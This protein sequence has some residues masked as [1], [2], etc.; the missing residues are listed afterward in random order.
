MHSMGFE[1]DC[2]SPVVRDEVACHT[3][4]VITQYSLAD[5]LINDKSHNMDPA[6]LYISLC[7]FAKLLLLGGE[8]KKGENF[9]K[10]DAR[11]TG[12]HLWG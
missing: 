8:K 7:G 11:H 5:R 10:Q 3:P 1:Q 12:Q 4:V 6:F 2:L 9:R